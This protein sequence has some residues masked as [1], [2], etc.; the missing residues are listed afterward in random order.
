VYFTQSN[1]LHTGDVLF[2]D[3]YPFIDLNSGGSIQGYI[4]AQQTILALTD[5]D[6]KIIPGHGD[7]ATA[8]DLKKSITMLTS[9][10]AKVNR[11]YSAG[12]TEAEI[13]EIKEITASYDAQGYGDGFINTERM[14]KTV[15]ADIT[16]KA[17]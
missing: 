14:L 16:N 9:I 4:K 12:K 5:T 10:Y 13:L 15:Y 7:L 17:K 6:T 8:S 3:R 1:V 2:K 11:Y